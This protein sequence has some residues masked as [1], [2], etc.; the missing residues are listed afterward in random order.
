MHRSGPITA[1]LG[2]LENDLEVKRD[3]GLEKTKATLDSE[4]YRELGLRT[5]LLVGLPRLPSLARPP[6]DLC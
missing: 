6:A 1:E 5:A 4:R 2:M 3:A